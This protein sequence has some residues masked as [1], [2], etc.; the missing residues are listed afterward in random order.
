M[1]L[2]VLERMISSTLRSFRIKFASASVRA[3]RGKYRAEYGSSRSL[4][5]RSCSFTDSICRRS[6]SGSSGSELVATLAQYASTSDLVCHEGKRIS[7]LNESHARGSTRRRSAAVTCRVAV[8]EGS[9][10][11]DAGLIKAFK[12]CVIE[13]SIVLLEMRKKSFGGR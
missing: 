12:F 5:T 10:P 1:A 4:T 9:N 13:S 8:E 3:S 6:K 11:A 7:F 2:Q